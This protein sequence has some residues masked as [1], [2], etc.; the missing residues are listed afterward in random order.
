M[1]TPASPLSRACIALAILAAAAALLAGCG[2]KSE[3]E[4]A[5]AS[6]TTTTSTGRATSFEIRGRWAGT[7]EQKGIGDFAV[8]ATIK[9]PPGSK[10]GTV[11]YGG[12][13]C[14]GTWKYLGRD[15]RAYRY[16]ETITR[17]TSSECKG[18]GTVT[19]T[20]AGDDQLDYQFRGGGVVSD[21]ELEPAG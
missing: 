9:A 16:R 3:P 13:N 1:R 21:G 2:E 18:T 12:I 14:S 7:L 11:R 8:N 5:G 20:P 10:L 15:G 6:S 19:L 17:G 4:L